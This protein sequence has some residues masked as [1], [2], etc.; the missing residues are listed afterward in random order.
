MK[1]FPA[2][3]DSFEFEVGDLVCMLVD[4]G[5]YQDTFSIGIIQSFE[6]GCPMNRFWVGTDDLLLQ[7]F[8]RDCVLLEKGFE[9]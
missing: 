2:M 4:E 8:P 5:W 7:S 3:S 9:K 1:G 6:E